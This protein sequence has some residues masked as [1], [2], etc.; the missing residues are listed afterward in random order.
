MKS[1]EIRI[2]GSFR[3]NNQAIR[4]FMGK[5]LSDEKFGQLTISVKNDPNLFLMKIRL[6]RN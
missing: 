2:I 4:I 3:R 1:I 6:M 5:K